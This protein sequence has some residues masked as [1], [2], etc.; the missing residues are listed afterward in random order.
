MNRVMDERRLAGAGFRLHGERG[1]IVPLAALLIVGLVLVVAMVG[2]WTEYFVRSARAQW[3][4]DAAALAA[5]GNGLTG[6]DVEAARLLAEA[7]GAVLVVVSLADESGD[8][9]DDLAAPDWAEQGGDNA[10]DRVGPAALSPV[11][12]VEVD[13]EGVRARSA[14]RRFA[15]RHR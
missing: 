3:A 1:S 13:F 14:A 15:S 10:P 12:V 8:E 2:V 9:V 11:V 4:A 7:N 5:A 6:S